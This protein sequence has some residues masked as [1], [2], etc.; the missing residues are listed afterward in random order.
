MALKKLED[1]LSRAA[2]RAH[3]RE[4]KPTPVGQRIV[5]QA[6]RV[7]AEAR[8]VQDLAREGKDELV[9]ALRPA[10]RSTRRPLPAAEPRAVLRQAVPADAA[11][12]RGKLYRRAARTALR[13]KRAGR[14]RHRAAGRSAGARACRCTTR[15]SSPG[16]GRQWAHEKSIPA[17][18]ACRGT[19][20]AAGPGHC[21]RDR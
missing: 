4:V 14:R 6:R 13:D 18:E 11:G 7:L 20:A 2:V 9:G 12:D 1:E 21:F 16:A 15:I 10:A 5:E 8:R 19:P 3:A 17:K